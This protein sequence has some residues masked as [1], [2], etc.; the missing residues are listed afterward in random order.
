MLRGTFHEVA[1]HHNAT[2]AFTVRY[3][4]GFEAGSSRHGVLLLPLLWLRP[5]RF[6]VLVS[7]GSIS[8]HRLISSLFLSYTF[9]IVPFTKPGKAE[10]RS[11]L[12]T[13]QICIGVLFAGIVKSHA[14]L[15]WIDFWWEKANLCIWPARKGKHCISESVCSWHLICIIQSSNSFLLH[16]YI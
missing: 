6:A 10:D 3:Q 7:I 14:C 15:Y 13:E 9:W 4:L 8:K 5:W 16:V 2:Q 1:G 12:E 11:G